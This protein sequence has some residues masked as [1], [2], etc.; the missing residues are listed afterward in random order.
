[1]CV[2]QAP[3]LCLFLAGSFLLPCVLSA[4]DDLFGRKESEVAGLI[5][6]I[7]DLKQDQKRRPT[8]VSP[9]DYAGIITEFLE[10]NWD[11]SVL[12]QYFR[13]ARPL[14][15]TQIFIP[16]MGAGEAPKAFEVQNVMKPSVW[17]VHYKGQVSPPEDGTY[18]FICYADDMIAVGVN[19]RTVANGSHHETRMP[20]WE[21]PENK[22]AGR[23]AN[24]D[25]VYGDWVGMKKDEPSDLDVVVGE[26][27]GGLFCAFLLYE[28]QGENYPPQGNTFRYPIFQ[29]A[30][31]SM[32]EYGEREA[33]PHFK[34]DRLW[35]AYQ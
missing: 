29:L 30:P 3:C 7:Y 11:E 31:Y 15:T 22:K 27:P 33:P 4:Q 18:R 16:L 2:R 35:K 8:G 26:R 6:I 9:A 12:N 10:K 5:G 19:G 17:V 14:Y 34:T 28:K 25:L 20:G 21:S 13:A 23:A 1:M 24:G 32:P